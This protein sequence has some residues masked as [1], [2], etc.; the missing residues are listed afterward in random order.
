MISPVVLA[1][2][3]GRTKCGIAVVSCEGVLHKDVCPV[4]QLVPR[5]L[6]A[7]EATG[8]CLIVMGSGTNGARLARVLR[9][10]SELRNVELVLVDEA[11]TTVEARKRFFDENPPR[12]LK[13]LIPRGL[14]K[15]SCAVDDYVAVILA[16]R[17]LAERALAERAL[18]ERALAER[19]LAERKDGDTAQCEGD[20]ESG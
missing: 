2:D 10:Q 20:G 3:P 4:L 8:A 17:A 5:V 14:L 1:V 19:A 6:G 15:P 16:E 18:A 11:F 13:R 9:Q 12:G 7:M